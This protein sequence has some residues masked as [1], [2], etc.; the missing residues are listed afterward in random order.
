MEINQLLRPCIQRL[1]AYSSA[2]NEYSGN[3]KLLLDANESPFDN[4]VNRYPDPLQRSLKKAIAKRN[5]ML[6]N[7]VFLGNGSDE[8]LDLLLRAFCEPGTDDILILPPT[9][10]MYKVLADI[11]DV[12]TIEVPLNEDFSLNTEAI[13]SAVRKTTKIIFICSPNNPTGNNMNRAA[14]TT[15]LDRFDG[16]VVV[17]EAYIDFSEEQSFI[18]NL[19]KH[20]NLILNQTFS[21]SY[22]G[23]G[24]RLGMAFA[25]AEIIT[26]LNR[27]KPPYNINQLTQNAALKL[28][29]NESL[30]NAN[31]AAILAQKKWLSA[32]LIQLKSVEKIYPSAANFL[33]VRF[34]NARLIYRQL[35][36]NGIIVR[37][38][39]DELNCENCLRI[40][41]GTKKENELLIN[42]LKQ[43]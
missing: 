29:E 10:G 15:I 12:N 34:Y 41:V 42:T 30:F 14:I 35:K 36:E 4:G 37:D 3:A 2:R 1:T 40:T 7:Q 28:Y 31:I 6:P 22:S 19:S 39:S 24:L 8:T 16:L 5:N 20:P 27:I 9:Y 38:R 32:H 13:I 33:L 11:N 17:D 25:S 18:K 23:A 21:K 43:L 26:I